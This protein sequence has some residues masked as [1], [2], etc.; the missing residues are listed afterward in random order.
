[1]QIALEFVKIAV[2]LSEVAHAWMGI[3][4]CFVLFYS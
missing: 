2:K 1:M 3:L 4:F